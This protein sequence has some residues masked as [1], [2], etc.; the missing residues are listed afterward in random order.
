MTDEMHSDDQVYADMAGPITKE[1]LTKVT[2]LLVA[3]QN[4]MGK[5]T[6][7]TVFL[8]CV[9]TIGTMGPAYCR[10]AAVSLVNRAHEFDEEEEDYDVD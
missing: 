2:A 6:L 1:D 8:A 9:N 4:A 3:W 7:R 5:E 10:L